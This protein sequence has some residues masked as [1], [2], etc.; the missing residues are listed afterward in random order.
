MPN[1]RMTDLPQ[2]INGPALGAV[3]VTPSDT[4]A[5]A[6]AVRAVTIGTGGVL[7][8]EWPLGTIHTTASLP[9]GTYAVWAARIRATNT[10]AAQI[11]GWI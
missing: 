11:T 9:A 7:C 3:A 10:T 6:D 5:L 1:P 4:V 2:T 8:Y